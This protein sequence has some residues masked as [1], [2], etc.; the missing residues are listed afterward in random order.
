MRG[1]SRMSDSETAATRL[2]EAPE[3][4]V[5]AAGCKVYRNEEVDD[6]RNLF[7]I[8]SFGLFGRHHVTVF[9]V[10]GDAA[11]IKL[12]SKHGRY[13]TSHPSEPLKKHIEAL[14]ALGFSE[15]VE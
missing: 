1:S 12:I 14:R 9:A 5:E 7:G 6:A 2:M 15:L 8:S 11:E 3:F 4:P 13:W 10:D